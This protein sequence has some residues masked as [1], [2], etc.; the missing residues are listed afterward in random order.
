MKSSSLL[1]SERM[2]NDPFHYQE[3]LVRH[4]QLF[5]RL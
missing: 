1:F 2:P 5:K 4:H 3:G